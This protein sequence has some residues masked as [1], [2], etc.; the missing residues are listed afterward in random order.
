MS[1]PRHFEMQNRTLAR[2][3]SQISTT[4]AE[5]ERAV[6]ILDA[7]IAAEEQRTGINDRTHF[8][9][10]TAARNMISRRDNLKTTISLLLPRLSRLDTTPALAS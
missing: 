2:E 9:Y 8:A 10:S 5:M 6:Q 1:Y 4:I 7:D 3:V